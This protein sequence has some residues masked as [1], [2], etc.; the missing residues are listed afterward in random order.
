MHSAGL[1]NIFR[2]KIFL[3]QPLCEIHA[4]QLNT[5]LS[6]LKPRLHYALNFWYRTT[7]LVLGLS[8]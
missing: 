1:A 7:F 4:A 6:W 3:D 8:K 2:R 5:R